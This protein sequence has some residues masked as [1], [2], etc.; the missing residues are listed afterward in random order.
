MNVRLRPKLR[1]LKPGTRI[2]SHNYDMGS[3][4]K[5]AKSFVVENSLVHFWTVPKR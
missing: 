2:V 3:G 5:P 4:W 1:A